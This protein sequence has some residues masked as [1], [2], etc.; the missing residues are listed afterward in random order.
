MDPLREVAFPFASYDYFNL[1]DA[2]GYISFANLN[3]KTVLVADQLWVAPWDSNRAWTPSDSIYRFRNGVETLAADYSRSLV[4]SYDNNEAYGSTIQSGL[5][6]MD[7]W[8]EYLQQFPG[9][10]GIAVSNQSWMCDRKPGFG[11]LNCP[12]E[13]LAMWTGN[14]FLSNSARIVQFEPFWYFFAWPSGVIGDFVP[15]LGN[16]TPAIGPASANTG[17]G[18]PTPNLCFLAQTLGVQLSSCPE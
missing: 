3:Q 17:L 4:L 2:Q 18:A 1:A 10:Q 16:L 9:I 15:A 8:S 13:Y 12:P 14:A 5:H 6:R 7:N 11:P